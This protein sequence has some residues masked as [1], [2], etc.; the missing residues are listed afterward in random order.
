MTLSKW[1]LNYLPLINPNGISPKKSFFFW[2][3]IKH[4]L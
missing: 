3:P 2:L 1:S 4:Y